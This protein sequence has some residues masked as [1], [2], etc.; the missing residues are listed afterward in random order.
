M[1]CL[2]Y[3]TQGC[4]KNTVMGAGTINR[5]FTIQKKLSL[6]CRGSSHKQCVIHRHLERKR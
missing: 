6:L 3:N 5:V 2:S 1:P 4:E